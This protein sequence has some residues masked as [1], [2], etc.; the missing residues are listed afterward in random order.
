LVCETSIFAI[1][2]KYPFLFL[3]KF[4][5]LLFILFLIT[6]FF[7]IFLETIGETFSSVEGEK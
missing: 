1:T 7:E 2:A 4:L 3:N 5:I 6:A